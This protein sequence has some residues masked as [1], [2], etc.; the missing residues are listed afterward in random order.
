MIK[1]DGGATNLTFTQGYTTKV[2]GEP[3]ILA[4]KMQK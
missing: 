3:S 2:V 4:T 1:K